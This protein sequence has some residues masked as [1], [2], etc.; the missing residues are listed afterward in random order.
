MLYA[1]ACDKL[2]L[3]KCQNDASAILETMRGI[4]C[5]GKMGRVYLDENEDLVPCI[6]TFHSYWLQKSAVMQ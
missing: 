2:P 5:D 6:V 3:D 4:S 1:R